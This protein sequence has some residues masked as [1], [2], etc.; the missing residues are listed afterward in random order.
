LDCGGEMGMSNLPTWAGAEMI[1]MEDEHSVSMYASSKD[2]EIALKRAQNER[3]L[4][5]IERQELA[6]GD[7]SAEV[8]RLKDL[9]AAVRGPQPKVNG[10]PWHEAAA[11][12]LRGDS[13]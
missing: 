6:L 11:K 7:M 10:V 13:D 5:T 12:A 8:A 9:V 3:L 2:A 1:R 4:D